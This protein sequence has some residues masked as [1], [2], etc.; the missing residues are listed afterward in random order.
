MRR[1]FTAIDVCNIHRTWLRPIYTWA[2]EFRQV[3]I[4]KDDFPFAA[5]R[6]IPKLMAKL[7]DGPLRQYTPCRFDADADVAK[8]L[9]IVHAE[10]MLI[11]PFRE[12]NGRAG[13]ILAILMGLQAKIPPLDFTDIRGRKRQEYF[14]AIRAGLGRDYLPME[15]IFND[16][17]RKTRRT[18]L[19]AGL[20]R[21]TT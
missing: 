11:H 5:A 12:G 8:A 17:V 18:A 3:N 10:L 15:R 9:A 2:G 19:R 4:S 7:E 16:V 13:R 6:E 14:A 21:R 1:T 20:G